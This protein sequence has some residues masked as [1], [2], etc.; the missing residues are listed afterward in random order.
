MTVNEMACTCTLLRCVHD[1]ATG[2][3][4]DTG[5]VMHPRE[6]G[7]AG[8]LETDPERITNACEGL[9]RDELT[10]N[11]QALERSLCRPAGHG[12]DDSSG[13]QARSVLPDDA[14]LTLGCLHTRCL[15]HAQP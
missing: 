14:Q 12:H 11:M 9:T 15:A 4:V 6:R 1:A 7:L 5:I 8:D 10:R 2:E 3:R 13:T